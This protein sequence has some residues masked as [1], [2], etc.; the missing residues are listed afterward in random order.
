VIPV[1]EWK[2][3]QKVI[4][5]LGRGKPKK[6]IVRIGEMVSDPDIF[7]EIFREH[8]KGTDME[9]MDIKVESVP[10]EA[11]CECGWAGRI[12]VIAH[13][14]FIRCPRCGKVADVLKGNELEIVSAE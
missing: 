7:M 8:V 9:G 14:H 3:V 6:A 12:K 1:H 5:E 4:D 2:A 13:L 10:V 11:K